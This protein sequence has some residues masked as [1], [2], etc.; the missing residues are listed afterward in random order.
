MYLTIVIPAYNEEKRLKPTLESLKSYL[1]KK[2]FEYEV[3]IV[4]N[5]STDGTAKLVLDFQKHFPQLKL[6]NESNK[7][8]GF[9]VRRGIMAGRGQYRLFMDADNSTDISHIDHMLPHFK[10]GYDV[11]IGSLAD[12]DSKVVHGGGEPIWRV[13]LGKLGNLFIQVFAVWGIFDTQRGF[14]IFS[15]RAADSIF[16][17]LTIFGWGFDVEVLAIAKKMGYKIKEAPV[18]WNNDPDSKVNAWA[19]PQVLMQT[20]KVSWNLHTGKYKIAPSVVQAVSE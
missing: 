18:T 2:D 19:Y 12:K 20:L 17:L 9:A 4:N 16:P 5:N 1:S 13:I 3:I 14:K 10:E 8:K 11:V 7:G 6:F 15:A